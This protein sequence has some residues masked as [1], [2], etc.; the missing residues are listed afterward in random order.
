MFRIAAF[1][2]N[3][4]KRCETCSELTINKGTRTTSVNDV[5]LVALFNGQHISQLFLVFQLLTSDK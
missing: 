1:E 3:T 5:T 4:R 2:K